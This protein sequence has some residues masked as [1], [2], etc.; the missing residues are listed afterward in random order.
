M[1]A[2]VGGIVKERAVAQQTRT[3]MSYRHHTRYILDI[4]IEVIFQGS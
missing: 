1:V 3:S 2:D 4:G